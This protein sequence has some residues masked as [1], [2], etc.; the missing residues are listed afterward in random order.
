MS[1]HRVIDDA[2]DR[3]DVGHFGSLG[4]NNTSRGDH[5]NRCNERAASA[6]GRAHDHVTDLCG[7][8]THPFAGVRRSSRTFTRKK[9]F[10]DVSTIRRWRAL[11]KA[12][13]WCS[14]VVHLLDAMIDRSANTGDRTSGRTS[15]LGWLMPPIGV[16]TRTGFGPIST[17]KNGE[18]AC[19][20]CFLGW[21]RRP[22]SLWPALR[23]AWL[24]R[25]M[26]P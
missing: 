11:S 2:L 26:G 3:L 25:S 13:R 12:T 7:S 14:Y 15:P 21:S 4:P 24:R 19:V 16:R 6:T 17:G 22:A 5:H 1:A 9:S 18:T 20:P 8:S 23:P 10:A